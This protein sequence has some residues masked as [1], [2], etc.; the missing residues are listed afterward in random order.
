[1]TDEAMPTGLAWRGDGTLVVS[2]LE[3]RVWL[4][5]DTDGDGL[6][7]RLAP[8][9]DELAAP[10]GVAARRA[11]RS[12]S[13]TS[14]ACVRLSDDDGDGRADRTELVASGWGHTRDYH[15]W[16]VG[17]PRDAAGNYYVSLPCQQDERTEAGAKLRGTV[18]KLVPA[19]PPRRTI[20]GA[21]RSSNWPPACAFRRASRCRAAGELFVTDNQGNYTPFN[22]LNHIVDRRTLRVHQS[23]G[24]QA[25]L[26]SAVSNGRRRDSASLDPQ[27]QR[28][29]FSAG[30]SRQATAPFAGHLIGCEYDTRRLVRMSLE[31]SGRRISG[32][33]VSVLA[34]A[35]RRRGDVR[36]TAHLPGRAQRRSLR[37]Q[38]PR[39][40]LGRGREHRLARATALPAANCRRESPKSA[41]TQGGFAIEFTQPLDRAERP[42]RPAMRSRPTAAIRR[43][44]MAGP[45]WIAAPK[46]SAAVE[47]AEDGRQRDDRTGRTCAKDSSTSFICEI[48]PARESSSRPKPITPCGIDFALE[49]LLPMFFDLLIQGG[50]VID[51]TGAAA[52][53]GRRGDCPGSHRRRRT[54]GG[55][56]ALGTADSSTPAGWSSRRALSTCTRTP[57]AGSRRSRT[58]CPRLAR[59]SRPKC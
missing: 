32:R 25:R 29:L 54:A 51:G 34:R 15:D 6:E 53:R 52:P 40:R 9:S 49:E 23:P 58:S 24:V 8:F 2:S 13:S 48:W 46:R 57:T 4:G 39:Q 5:H 16:A 27:R 38:H 22:E 37:G 21:S 17:L 1:M 11:T 50:T 36:G 28:H 18:V 44:P 59:D 45:T 7:D 47:V 19:Q 31:Q 35:G 56:L 43:R 55:R 12:T 3:G 20:R 41:R 42:T 30:R 14:T 33:R 10:F 26:E